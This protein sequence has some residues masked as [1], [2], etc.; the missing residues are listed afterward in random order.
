MHITINAQGDKLPTQ[1]QSAKNIHQLS[2]PQKTTL[3]Q[4]KFYTKPEKQEADK[5]IIPTFRKNEETVINSP[6]NNNEGNTQNYRILQNMKS[7][8][9]LKKN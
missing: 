4:Y 9:F 5:K 2:P 7:P 6:R 1:I 3:P 8:Y